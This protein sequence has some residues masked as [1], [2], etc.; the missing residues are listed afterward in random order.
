[1]NRLSAKLSAKC[2]VGGAEYM[3]IP[4]SAEA[5]VLKKEMTAYTKLQ[6]FV[7]QNQYHLLSARPERTRN[8]RRHV[9]DRTR[10]A[11]SRL[12]V[13]VEP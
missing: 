13:L 2:R 3:E 5:K 12:A 4:F 9:K 7:D 6:A 10:Q 1:M 11:N 8:A